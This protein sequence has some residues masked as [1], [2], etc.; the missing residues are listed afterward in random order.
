[1]HTIVVSRDTA[2]TFL[3][4][5]CLTVK[6]RITI[7]EILMDLYI[8]VPVFACMF[9]HTSKTYTDYRF[10]LLKLCRTRE[11]YQKMYRLLFP[12]HTTPPTSH[13]AEK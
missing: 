2:D 8:C 13:T 12:F 7:T 9:I 5:I 6:E 4:L 10:Y 3:T 1:M 11:K